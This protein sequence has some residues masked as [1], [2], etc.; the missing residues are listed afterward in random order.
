M[1]V[2]NLQFKL[3]EFSK[4][5]DWEKF[6]S[7][8]NLAMALSGEAGE[9]LEIFQWMT[10]EQSKLATENNSC[11]QRISEELADVFIYALMLANKT[12][13]DIEDAVE[14]KIS[15]NNN[16]YPISSSKGNAVKYNRRG[17]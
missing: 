10:E 5:R 15:I 16:K 12:G 14:R 3:S 11:K 17:K 13:I 4:D 9:L 8:K 1:D 6:H 2:M 7:P